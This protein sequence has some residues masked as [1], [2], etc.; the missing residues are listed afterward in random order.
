MKI[1]NKII[2]G[3]IIGYGLSELVKLMKEEEKENQE[4]L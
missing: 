1:D 2:V 3:V 4:I